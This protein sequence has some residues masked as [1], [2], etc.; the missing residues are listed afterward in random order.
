MIKE[1]RTLGGSRDKKEV[2]E[3]DV[4]GCQ[5]KRW[6]QTPLRGNERNMNRL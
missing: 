3:R 2:C 5:K 1:I 4:G 6:G